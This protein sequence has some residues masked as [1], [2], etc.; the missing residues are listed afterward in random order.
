MIR[1]HPIGPWLVDAEDI[2]DPMNLT[3]R[4]YVNGELTQE[5]S[6]SQ[7]IFSIP[8]LIEY[9]SSFMTLS[10]GD[11]ILTGTPKGAV[12]TKIGD[13]VITEIEGIGRLLSTIVEDDG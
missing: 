7:M 9:L 11:M 5:G 13:E 2:K 10:P 12:D 3:L 8:F 6:T 1:A 4:T